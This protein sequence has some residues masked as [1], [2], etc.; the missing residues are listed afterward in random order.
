VSNSETC[1]GV[2]TPSPCSRRALVDRTGDSSAL[3][4]HTVPVPKPDADEVLISLDTAGV[5]IWDIGIRRHPDEVQHGGF[6]LVLGTDGTGTIAAVG[7]VVHDFKPRDRVVIHGASDGV[8]SLA[9][10]FAKLR[11]ARVL[12]TAFGEASSASSL[13]KC[14]SRLIWRSPRT[15]LAAETPPCSTMLAGG[16]CRLD[17]S[18]TA[19]PRGP[20]LDLFV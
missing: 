18:W 1:C 20:G 5:G 11:G 4:L 16:R 15:S 7:S 12:A 19:P 3:T 14:Y 17:L 2:V 9:I 13:A 10:Q 8:G 6:P